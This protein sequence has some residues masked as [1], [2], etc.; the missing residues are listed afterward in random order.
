MEQIL[1]DFFVS[2]SS[3]YTLDIVKDFLSNNKLDTYLNSSFDRAKEK[4]KEKSGYFPI[5]IKSYKDINLIDDNQIN[6]KKELS[7]FFKDELRNSQQ[8]YLWLIENLV[9]N[10]RKESSVLDFL[11]MDER[12][13]YQDKNDFYKIHQGSKIKIDEIFVEPNYGVYN[14][15]PNTLEY[16]EEE[17]E[18]HIEKLCNTLLQDHKVLFI[19]GHYGSG[20]TILSKKIL[21]R[22][23][24]GFTCFFDASR[25]CNKN[26]LDAFFEIP[27]KHL[28]ERYKKCYVFI[29]SLDD[30]SYKDNMVLETVHNLVT[31]YDNIF[32]V[33]NCRKPD[34][35]RI[36]DILFCL[37]YIYG[38]EVGIVELKKFN[39]IQQEQW[40][41]LYN[42][43]FYN[44]VDRQYEKELSIGKND[45]QKANKNLKVACQI[46]LILLMLLESKSVDILSKRQKWY[47]LFEEFVNKTILGKF[48]EERAYHK[49]LDEKRM[50]Q[51]YRELII[52][53]AFSV[54]KKKTFHSFIIQSNNNDDFI[55]DPNNHLYTIENETVKDIISKKAGISLLNNLDIIRFLNCYF[56]DYYNGSWKFKDNNILFFLCASKFFSIIKKISINYSN[57][58]DLPLCVEELRREFDNLS[59]HPV[60][61]E[62][63]IDEI[64]ETTKKEK[65]SILSFIKTLIDNNY[66]VNVPDKNRFIINYNKIRVDILLAIIFIRFNNESYQNRHL[67]H[68]FKSISQYY[69]YV[70]IID[71]DLAS[72]ILRYF[73][74]IPV[75]DADLKRINFK[76]YNW[77][78]SKFANV[79]FNQCK[80]D[81]TLLEGVL[82][83][84]AFLKLCYFK[85]VIFNDC[86]GKIV[87]QLS[88]LLHTNFFFSDNNDSSNTQ[89]ELHFKN[90]ILDDL[91]F[92]LGSNF[93]AKNAPLITFEK[94]EIRQIRMKNGYIK[95][96][97]D[98][99]SYMSNKISLDN[100]HVINEIG[101]NKKTANNVLF[102]N[103]QKF[104]DYDHWLTHLFGNQDGN[105]FNIN[106]G[107]ISSYE[108]EDF[109]W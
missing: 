52:E 102:K 87:F 11:D 91:F 70:K 75:K 13:K 10:Q 108:A 20:K 77:N 22:I 82:F 107:N 25:I 39:N 92:N 88:H 9:C 45:F 34:G 80:F 62:F 16:E 15:D 53:I 84:D 69:S 86:S 85:N 64:D 83:K 78:Y 55:L 99:L 81:N 101:C 104:N 98:I 95:I 5:M 68:C 67:N 73:R 57:G 4:F 93:N 8:S 71:K 36:N 18:E 63:I 21:M 97:I 19:F 66:I 35:L 48:R 27:I 38:A 43:K 32:F 40:I 94:C 3:S 56:F 96:K 100:V 44:A 109:Q 60:V 90:C 24:D 30:I 41:E 28:I 50:V 14:Y 54:L 37:S 59:L 51:E 2:L 7:N 33:I 61:I 1:L 103:L 12:E 17:H 6:A 89:I 105:K 72:I 29:D 58:I 42:S 49:F 31:L 65:I 76:G 26:D 74:Y 46:P 23:Y 106:Y 79:K 47:K